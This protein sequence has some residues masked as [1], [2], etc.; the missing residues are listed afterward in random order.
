MAK[1]Y[2]NTL[3]VEKDSSTEEIKKAYKRLA[4]QYHPDINKSPGA[5]D[6][7]KEINEAAAVLSDQKKREQYDRYGTADQSFAGYDFSRHNY[8]EFEDMDFDFDRIFEQFFG[9]GGRQR[10]SHRQDRGSD[11]E[12]AIEVSLDEAYKGVSKSMSLPLKVQCEVC[13]G[14]GAKSQSSIKTC[15]DCN[16]TGVMTRASRTAFGYFQT[17][18][19]CENCHG[20][21]RIITDRCA[22]CHGVGVKQATRKLSIDIPKGVEDGTVLRL[23]SQ[24]E[25]SRRGNR[26][27]L[28][29]V[30]RVRRHDSFS[31]K[32]SDLY[33]DLKLSFVQLALGDEIEIKTLDGKVKVTVP[34]GTQPGMMLRL[35]GKGMPVIGDDDKGDLYVTVQVT[36]T[37]KLTKKQKELLTELA[38]EFKSEQKDSIFSSSSP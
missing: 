4:K 11:V 37:E 26:G 36:V 16:G 1:D 25:T 33:M 10:Q 34:Q 7:F 2:Y 24:G 32:G 31:R 9:F 8:S 38:K 6:K 35:R 19:T 15:G 3:G 22:E 13:K 5:T 17:Q 28:Y 21:G 23:A 30:I 12:L 20:S 14:L 29:V 18:T 27:D